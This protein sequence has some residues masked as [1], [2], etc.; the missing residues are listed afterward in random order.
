M[1]YKLDLFAIFIFLGVVQSLFLSLFF[2]SNPNR[3]RLFNVFYGVLL[4]S[5]GASILEIFLMYTGYI[6]HCLYLVDFSEP[7][8][9][10]IGPSFYLMVLATTRGTI[11]R[12]QYLHFLFPV[13]YL[14]LVV[15][16]F[17]LPEDVK[18][19]SWVESYHLDLPFRDYAGRDP[20]A[21]WVTDHHTDM[22]ILSFV[23]YA[24]LSLVEVIKVFRAKRQPFLNPEQPSLKNLRNG[25][26]QIV[27]TT[28]LVLIVKLFNPNDTGDHMIAAY[29]SLCVYLI[30]IFVIRQSGFFQPAQLTD[31]AKYKSS[32]LTRE[33]QEDL[34]QRLQK[35]MVDGKPF[36]A[37]DFSLP[38]LAQKLNT[39]THTLSQVINAGLGKN[40]FE[41]TAE[42]RVGEAKKLL[43]EQKHV[44]V[45]EIAEQV[46]YN[47]KSSFN[48]AFKRIT[49]QTPS[50]FRGS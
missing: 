20:R 35:V 38:D 12:E 10:V 23:T 7:L 17:L 42:Y 22:A 16:F 46:G 2:F 49:G 45:E 33:Q 8:A 18:Y 13:I 15:P 39:S 4:L 31:P 14:I 5:M 29:I 40:F 6:V 26:I 50:D 36:L 48:S 21:F 32:V 3:K 25:T 37:S 24:V 47:S 11:S 27:S 9:F 28:L 34:L 41:M 43:K 44:K 1:P 19:N 30:S